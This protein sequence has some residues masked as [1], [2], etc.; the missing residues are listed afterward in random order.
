MEP[1]E[2]LQ[3]TFDQKGL[4]FPPEIGHFWARSLGKIPIKVASH[5]HGNSTASRFSTAII[6]V[7]Q[8]SHKENHNIGGYSELC[9][10]G[11]L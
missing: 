3:E 8:G 7:D 10:G 9:P 11:S 5:G 1:Q 4:E 6:H 2:R